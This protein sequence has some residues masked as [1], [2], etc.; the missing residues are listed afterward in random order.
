[1]T[2]RAW[3]LW[4]LL[5]RLLLSSVGENDVSKQETLRQRF[6]KFWS[7][8]WSTLLAM[9]N[10]NPPRRSRPRHTNTVQPEKM[11][12]QISKGML[13]KACAQFTSPGIAEATPDVIDYL[14]DPARRPVHQ[15]R[16]LPDTAPTQRIELD[17]K[18]MAQTIR[19]IRR[20]T[21][22]GRSG[23]RGEHLP[24]YFVRRG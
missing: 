20:G 21:A 7:G 2:L 14:T 15:Q 8:E 24:S 18:L 23:L 22:P 1:M 16:V 10:T 17:R 6:E 5:P 12:E 13:S 9:V 11:K 3:K 4:F 19:G